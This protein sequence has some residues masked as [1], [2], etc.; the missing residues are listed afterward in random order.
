MASSKAGGRASSRSSIGKKRADEVIRFVEGTLRHTKGTFA[1]KPFKLTQWQKKRYWEPLFGTL[2]PD[3]RRQIRTVFYEISRKNGKSQTA[4]ATGI[5]MVFIDGEPGAEVLILASDVDQARIIFSECRRMVEA[6]PEILEAFRPVIYR[7][8]IEY[9]ET[10]SVLRVLSADEKGIHGRNPSCLIL[11]EFHTIR[12]PKAREFY[13]AATTAMG[14]RANPLT[15]LVSTAGFDRVSPCFELH[16]YAAQIR[17]GLREDPSFLSVYYGAPDDADWRDPEVW[18]LANPALTGPDAFLSMEYLENEF[19]QATALPGREYAFR[20][21]FLNQ[22][23]SSASRWIDLQTYDASN[24]HPIVESAYIGEKFWAGVDLGGVSDLSVCALLFPCPHEPDALDVIIRAFVPEAAVRDGKN[25]DLYRAWQRAGLLTVTPGS[26]SDEP[27]FVKAVLADAERFGCR[28]LGIDRLF[29]AMRVSSELA[30]EGISVSPV[31]MG[32]TSLSPLVKEM[33]RLILSKKL[34]HGGNPVLRFAVD[35]AEMEH[36][37]A[38]NQKPVRADRSK[39]IDALI[40]VLLGLDRHLREPIPVE[41]E[42]QVLV[43]GG[44]KRDDGRR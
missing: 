29:Q 25:R 12:T 42:Y 2:L 22:W 17:A 5:V 9:P 23:V 27:A 18:K 28:S 14:T 40:A 36:D 44:P 32:F 31:G 35:A 19:R 30:A 39:K 1:G 11:D 26:V 8:A 34:H 3:G 38:G 43:F 7:D 10:N 41:P 6:S 24:T 21:L 37:S 20:T 13:N 33:E 15:L 4:G 16:E